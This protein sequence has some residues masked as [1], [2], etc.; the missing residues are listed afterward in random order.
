MPSA[1]HLDGYRKIK[2]DNAAVA[3][4]LDLQVIK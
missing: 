2:A 1:S 4:P 3:Y